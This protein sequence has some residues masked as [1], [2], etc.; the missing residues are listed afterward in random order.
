MLPGLTK[1]PAP[2]KA[3]ADF[4]RIEDALLETAA[5]V[6]NGKALT[7]PTHDELARWLKRIPAAAKEAYPVRFLA[8]EGDEPLRAELFNRYRAATTLRGKRTDQAKRRT[9]RQLLAA[10]DALIEKQDRSTA[11]KSAKS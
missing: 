10:R 1:L 2:L 4:L 3:L 8:A 6:D 5:K 7:E 9:V 11:K